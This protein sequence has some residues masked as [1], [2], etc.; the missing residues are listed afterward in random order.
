M[1]SGRLAIIFLILL[2]FALFV[3]LIFAIGVYKFEWKG[4]ATRAFA[5]IVPL[6]VATVNGRLISLSDWWDLQE[7][8]ARF[9]IPR[10]AMGEE[11]K[12]LLLEHLVD[13]RIISVLF[14]RYATSSGY[15]QADY[16]VYLAQKFRS[17]LELSDKAFIKF[18]IFPDFQQTRLK[19]WW[20]REDNSSE[21]YNTAKST[22]QQI[23]D[24]AKFEDLAELRSDDEETKYIGGDLGF[25]A[26]ADLQPWLSHAI[27][28]LRVGEV[29]DIIPAPDGYYI[30]K[31]AGTSQEG[32]VAKIRVKQIYIKSESY[33]DFFESEKRKLKILVFKD[34]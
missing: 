16:E 32:E 22:H 13:S 28:G 23:A 25:L 12:K 24:G 7:L 14:K 9:A 17:A 31:L 2:S 30:L 18:V 11:R 27:S 21:P 19:I 5:R 15:S 10:D 3:C 6:P 26:I 4:K 8:D 34:L 29:T 33:E 20:Y 1:K